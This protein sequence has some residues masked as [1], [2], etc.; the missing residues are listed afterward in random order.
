MSALSDLDSSYDSLIE[1][2]KDLD[3]PE[4]LLRRLISKIMN[5]AIC[6]TY[7]IC[8]LLPQ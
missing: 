6:W 3:F 5:I 8:I 1:L 4:K 2:W 7:Y